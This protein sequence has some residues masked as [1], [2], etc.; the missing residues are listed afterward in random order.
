MGSLFSWE[1]LWYFLLFFYVLSCIGL[2]VIVLLQ[3]GKGSGFAGAFGLGG[4]SET[5]F[6]PRMSKSLPQRLTYIMAA[7]FMIIAFL[8]SMISGRLGKGVA[9]DKISEEISQE[10]DT[11]SIGD[12]GKGLEG[13]TSTEGGTVTVTPAAPSEGGTVTVTPAAPAEGGTVTVTPA[14]PAATAPG[15]TVTVTPETPAS[16]A[17]LAAPAA[18]AAPSGN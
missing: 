14:T 9:P 17:A 6:G 16:P 18:P 4:G 7:V 10:V 5:V 2:I 15:G 11:S 3:K 8:M 1:T 12:L 13:V